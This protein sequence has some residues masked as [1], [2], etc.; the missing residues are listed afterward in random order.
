[1]EGSTVIVTNANYTDAGTYSCEAVNEYTVN[2]KT[3][4]MLLVVDKMVDV[5]SEFTYS[6]LKKISKKPLRKFEEPKIR[7]FVYISIF[8]FAR[9]WV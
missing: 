7:T 2:G 3:S 9:K 5:R 8:K 6:F 1:M 4:K